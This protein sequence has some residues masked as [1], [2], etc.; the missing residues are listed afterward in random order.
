MLI[1]AQRESI[2]FFDKTILALT[3]GVFGLSIT[4]INQIAPE[5][6]PQTAPILAWAWGLFS[7]SLLSTLISFLTSCRA[8]SNAIKIF[9]WDWFENGKRPAQTK[10]R[11]VASC[12]TAVLNYISIT[13]FAI[14]VLALATFSFLN[15]P[16]K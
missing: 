13:M 8:C 2:S 15:L 9:E 12:V 6:K 14:G 1:E 5:I 11:N 10:P 4:F 3:A 16:I 7:A